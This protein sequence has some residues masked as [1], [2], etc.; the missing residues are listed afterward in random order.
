MKKNY[1]FLLFFLMGLA[2][3]K[4]YSQS[5]DVVK[6]ADSNIENL[7]IYPNPVS[8]GKIYITTSEY[9]LKKIEIFNVLGKKILSV[10]LY[11]N[12]LNISKLKTGIYIIK[13]TENNT[14]ATRKLIV[15]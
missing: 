6:P 13:I 12:E 3:F 10:S 14:T 7:T 15:K 4:G 8:Q 1:I 5:N 11:Q 9:A 2:S